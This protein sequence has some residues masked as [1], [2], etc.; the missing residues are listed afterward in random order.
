MGGRT[1]WP[2]DQTADAADAAERIAAGKLATDIAVW[3][4]GRPDA[5][6]R[7][8]VQDMIESATL[9]ETV[10]WIAAIA[11]RYGFKREAE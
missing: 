8:A 11:E 1:G 7:A 2:E 6:S 5:V 9:P 4:S 10:E 3:F